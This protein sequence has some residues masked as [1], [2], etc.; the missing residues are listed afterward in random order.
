[1]LRGNVVLRLVLGPKTEDVK[2]GWR[3]VRTKEPHILCCWLNICCVTKPRNFI[4]GLRRTNLKNEKT[5]T[6]FWS[7]K[8]NS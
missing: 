1:M 2:E 3:K 5:Y 8:V 7:R 4:G 6:I